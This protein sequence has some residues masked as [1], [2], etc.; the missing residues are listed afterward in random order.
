M[1]NI[2][3]RL[4]EGDAVDVIYLDFAKAFDKVDHGILLR[5]L[6]RLG[7]RGPLGKWIYSFLTGR[8]QVVKVNGEESDPI[9]VTSGVPQGTVLAGTLFI[10][11]MKTINENVTHSKVSSYAD[12]TKVLHRIRGKTDELKLQE[13]LVMIYNWAIE[14]NMMFNGEKFQVLRYGCTKDSDDP[15]Y[16][17]PNGASIPV[18]EHVKD[19]GVW[20]SSKGTFEYHINDVVQRASNMSGWVLRTFKSRSPTL[21]LTLFKT[22]VMSKLDY[23][24]PV[25]HPRSS[26]SLTTKI[27]RVQRSFTRK[28][29]GMNGLDYWLR[30]KLLRLYSVE[31]RRERFI[32]VYL[33]K[34]LHGFVPNIGMTYTENDR[35]GIHFNQPTIKKA[36]TSCYRQMRTQSFSYS[37]ARIY[38]SLPR[39][40]KRKQALEE[41]FDRVRVVEEFKKQ[42]DNFLT[43]LPDQ[44]TTPGLTR[45]AETNSIVDQVNYIED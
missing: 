10:C 39:H 33:F 12:D 18:H 21:M 11:M 25:Y 37:A 45:A 36:A 35:T 40:L 34:M 22:M 28:I 6:Q 7:V 17:A 4:E 23:C 30:L 3:E 9:P 2:V 43:T 32:I 24:S 20:M 26:V 44:P 27:E 15:E 1:E 19:L 29:E 38:N 13:D 16:K 41:N 42:L 5:T 31:R 8:S 14:K